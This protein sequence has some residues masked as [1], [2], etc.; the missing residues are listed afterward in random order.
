MHETCGKYGEDYAWTKRCWH[1]SHEKEMHI[2]KNNERVSPIQP[3]WRNWICGLQ[4]LLYVCHVNTRPQV[5][6]SSLTQFNNNISTEVQPPILVTNAL[7]S[8]YD[9][10]TWTRNEA[11]VLFWEW[12][13]G[14]PLWREQVNS[15]KASEE[16]EGMERL[17]GRNAHSSGNFPTC[18]AALTKDI[19]GIIPRNNPIKRHQE[20]FFYCSCRRSKN[21]PHRWRPNKIIDFVLVCRILQRLVD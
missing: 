5:P 18:D 2:N 11:E 4:P 3:L 6:C 16:P 12:V 13:L 8:T 15:W 9:D 14:R 17:S 10:G 21:K 20:G 1:T 19:K 7:T